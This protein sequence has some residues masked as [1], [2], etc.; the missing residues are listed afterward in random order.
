[1]FSD[2]ASKYFNTELPKELKKLPQGCFQSV[3]QMAFVWYTW[4]QL[5]REGL[6]PNR[7]WLKG[8]IKDC[9][10]GNPPF[11]GYEEEH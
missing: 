10:E 3:M 11:S 4:H 1:M 9:K 2:H 7:K 6:E 8:I 5:R